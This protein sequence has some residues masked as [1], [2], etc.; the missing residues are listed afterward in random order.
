MQYICKVTCRSIYQERIKFLLGLLFLMTPLSVTQAQQ[1]GQLVLEKGIV[2]ISNENKIQILNEIGTIVP[3]VINDQVHTATDSA[4][5]ILLNEQT[6]TITLAEN[7][8]FQV[9][10]GSD[11]ASN[12]HLFIGGINV[13][14]DPDRPAIRGQ[15]REF[16]LRIVTIPIAMR[17]TNFDTRVDE[18]GAIAIEIYEGIVEILLLGMG[19]LVAMT[20]EQGDLVRVTQSSVTQN[21]VTKSLTQFVAENKKEQREEVEGKKKS[22]EPPSEKNSNPN[23]NQQGDLGELATIAADAEEVQIV[24]EDVAD[25][26]N[27]ESEVLLSEESSIVNPSS[28]PPNED[29]SEVVDSFP[30]GEVKTP[31]AD[32]PA[33]NA[34]NPESIETPPADDPAENADNPESIET[35]PADDPAENADNS[36]SIEAPPANDPAENADNSESIEAPPAN[37]PAENAD[38]DNSKNADNTQSLVNIVDEAQEAIDTA[39]DKASSSINKNISITIE[40]Q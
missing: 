17:G 36:E 31:P 30:T 2:K 5:K 27:T 8:I 22:S 32:D 15:K 26:E 35:P 13:A 9:G 1:R 3:V 19:D 33:E 21:G 4:V 29:S 38:T 23:E 14:I 20:L 28:T 25:T 40:Y 6:E 37:D 11:L 34:D 16:H 18:T 24:I 7:T 10:D 12:A 39:A